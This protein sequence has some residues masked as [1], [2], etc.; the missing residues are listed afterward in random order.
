[1]LQ[2][3]SSPFGRK[4]A[5]VKSNIG[6]VL[7]GDPSPGAGTE[8]IV[9]GIYNRLRQPTSNGVAYGFLDGI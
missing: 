1:M 2:I 3:K 9:L 5:A 4:H 8:N 6:I 7:T